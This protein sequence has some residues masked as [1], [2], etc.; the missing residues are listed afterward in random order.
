MEQM[1]SGKEIKAEM[2]DSATIYFGSVSGFQTYL[3]S[4]SPIE[5]A[6]LLNH[7]YSVLD[8]VVLN[9]SVFKLETIANTYLVSLSDRNFLKMLW[10][11]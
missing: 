5:I 11:L 9:Y 3:A 2:F 1:L 6:N 8:L 7:I 4:H 10:R